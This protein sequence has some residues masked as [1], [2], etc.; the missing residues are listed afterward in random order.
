MCNYNSDLL[1]YVYNAFSEISGLTS[2]CLLLTFDS[3]VG[4]SCTLAILI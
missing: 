1:F 4:M 2:I 3:N